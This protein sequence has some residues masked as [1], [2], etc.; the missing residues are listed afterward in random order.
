MVN[1][2]T[3]LDIEQELI[4]ELE[5][6]LEHLKDMFDSRVDVTIVV[7]SKRKVIDEILFVSSADDLRGLRSAINRTLDRL[8]EKDK[9]SETDM[10]KH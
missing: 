6:V 10:E 9:N 2:D 7:S 5:F 3:E 4:D 1:R 8:G